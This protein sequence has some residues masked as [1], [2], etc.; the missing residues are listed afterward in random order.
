MG[1]YPVLYYPIGILKREI[2]ATMDSLFKIPDFPYL[3]G[4]S[5]LT[6]FGLNTTNESGTFNQQVITKLYSKY[7]YNK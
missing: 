7:F 3:N 4:S 5:A 6:Q 1:S 2:A